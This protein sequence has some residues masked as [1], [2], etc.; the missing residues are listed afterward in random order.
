MDWLKRITD[1]D[2]VAKIQTADGNWNYD[3][4]MM[5]MA[6]G[7]LLAHHIMTNEEQGSMPDYKS[8]PGKWLIDSQYTGLTIQKVSKIVSTR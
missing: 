2:N 7:L 4:Y 5:G 3:P 8:A 6:N 1:L